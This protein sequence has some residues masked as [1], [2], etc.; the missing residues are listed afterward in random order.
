MHDSIKNVNSFNKG[1]KTLVAL[2]ETSVRVNVVL[3][4]L[5]PKAYAVLKEL[6]KKLATKSPA[7]CALSTVDPSLFHGCLFIHN[8]ATPLHLDH[9]NALG[10][11]AVLLVQ[12]FFTGGKLYLPLLDQV[13]VF[14]PGTLCLLR[15]GLLPD[16]ILPFHNGQR[17]SIAHFVLQSVM[18]QN[19][20]RV[21]L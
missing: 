2:G 3:K 16:M 11:W 20:V 15:G 8:R 13:F 7:F 10:M 12:G 17:I 5:D 1:T 18:L 6:W 14:L 21:N 9:R 4:Q 19:N